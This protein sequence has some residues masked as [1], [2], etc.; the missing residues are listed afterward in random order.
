MLLRSN[1]INDVIFLGD[2][3]CHDGIDPVL[4]ERNL[5][6]LRAYNLGS[7]APDWARSGIS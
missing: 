5:S 4:F 3:T 6:Q 2:S 1:E 7:Q